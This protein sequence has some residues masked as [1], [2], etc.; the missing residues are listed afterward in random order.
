MKAKKIVFDA[1][2]I[3][4]LLAKERGWESIRA[5]LPFAVMSS[6]NVAETHQHL[7]DRQGLSKR[8]SAN[9]L[10]AANVSIFDFDHEQALIS[11]ELIV[12]TKEYGLSIADR[13]CIALGLVTKLPILTCDKI[14]QR[15]TIPN[16]EII[17]AR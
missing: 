13:A 5:Y 10:A 8:E 11:A 1:S 6:V 16:I 2:A 3:I 7:I 12:V 15:I 14:W 9:L 4:A 17:L